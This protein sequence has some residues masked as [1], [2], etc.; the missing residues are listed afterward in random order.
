MLS[1]LKNSLF[2]NPNQKILNSYNLIINQINDLED[3]IKLLN[4][5]DIR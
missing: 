4:D 3:K 1:F 2:A 5:N